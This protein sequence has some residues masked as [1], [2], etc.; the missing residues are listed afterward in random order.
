MKR[1]PPTEKSPAKIGPRKATRAV[2]RYK[3]GDGETTAVPLAE[4][5]RQLQ[6]Q[7]HRMADSD[8]PELRE[9]GER[10]LRESA[11]R[12]AASIVADLQRANASRNPRTRSTLRERI[13]TVMR[14]YKTDGAAFKT[15]LAAWEREPLDGLSLARDGQSPTLE[16]QKYKVDDENAEH[17]KGGAYT[18]K[19]LRDKLWPD[20]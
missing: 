8:S 19:T 14:S 16:N 18:F 20:A 3:F 11:E 9:A 2:V 10:K 5:Q 4:V 15:F 1:K 6:R 12:E 7:Y 13:V 17:L